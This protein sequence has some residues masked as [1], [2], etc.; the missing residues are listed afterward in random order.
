MEILTGLG[1]A[2]PA[3]LNAPL[4]LLLVA[5]ANRFTGFVDLP[6]GYEDLSSWWA[7]GAL[8]VWLV[9]EE[10]ADKV[11]GADHVNDVV[12]T[13]V[14][15]AAGGLLAVSVIGGELPDGVSA[16][17]GVALAGTAHATK[18]GARPAV[19]LGTLGMGN[20]VAS[21][22]EDVVAVLAVIVAL[23]IPVLVVLV[24]AALLAA[25]AFVFVRWRAVAR[26]R[27]VPQAP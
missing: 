5:L 2:A 11:P 3:G 20:P 25:A 26:R 19:T 14:R 17:L 10:I 21:V 23:V 24:L 12:M 1:L 4:T 22:V 8:A 18:A 13:V 15:P 9:V 6:A 7:I 27:A 16:V